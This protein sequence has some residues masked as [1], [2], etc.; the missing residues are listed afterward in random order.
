MPIQRAV[1]G[2]G[3]PDSVERESAD[4]IAAET[5]TAVPKRGAVTGAVGEAATGSDPERVVRWIVEQGANEIVG[6][7]LT[8]R[9][10]GGV[11]I[12][13]MV[14]TVR[15]ANREGIIPLGGEGE[16]GVAGEALLGGK[17]LPRGAG[18]VREAAAIRSCPDA[19]FTR[20]NGANHVAGKAV[21][22][23]E[24]GEALFAQLQKAGGIGAQPQV[25]FAIFIEGFDSGS[26]AARVQGF[27]LA[28]CI[29]CDGAFGAD[30]KRALAVF[31]E[32]EDPVCGQ[33]IRGGLPDECAGWGE[34]AESS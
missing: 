5:V 25:S 13:Q 28:V 14:E 18:K 20:Q 7:G 33:A 1:A 16:D 6:Q 19:V 24:G 30:P 11:T 22:G 27:E 34:D 21:G 26:A 3:G 10:R 12:R 31:E 4:Q 29:A 2:C 17:G 23:G 15:R 8:V 9:R 32:M